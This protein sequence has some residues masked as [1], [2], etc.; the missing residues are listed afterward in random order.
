LFIAALLLGGAQAACSGSV[1]VE[2]D[3]DDDGDADSE[4]GAAA[5]PAEAPA[6]LEGNC[7]IVCDA[8]LALECSDNVACVSDCMKSFA[9]AGSCAGMLAEYVACFADH[10][11]N[12]SCSVF[13]YQCDGSYSAFATCKLGG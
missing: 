12:V 5:I 9:D 10:I 11:D 3:L 6:E 4:P 8:L 2:G 1:S 13:P 7:G